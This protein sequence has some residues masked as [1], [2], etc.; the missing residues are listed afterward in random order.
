MNFSLLKLE[1][2]SRNIGM[3]VLQQVLLPSIHELLTSMNIRHFKFKVTQKPDKWFINYLYIFMNSLSLTQSCLPEG[4]MQ[5]CY[6]NL[7]TLCIFVG[8]L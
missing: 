7:Q 1:E 6:S 5:S 3:Q 2:R 4:S 8:E